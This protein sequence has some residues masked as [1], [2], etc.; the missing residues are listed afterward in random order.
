MTTAKLATAVLTGATDIG[1]AIA[2][3]DL[4]LV[5]DGAGGTLRKTAAS[6]LK[7]YITGDLVK[8]GSATIGTSAS[9][10]LNG[11]FTSDYEN[12][13]F[14]LNNIH[15][16]TA[17]AELRMRYIFGG[18]VASGSNYSH[19]NNAVVGGSGIDAADENYKGYG[20]S[21]IMLSQGQNTNQDY[22]GSVVLN[23]FQPLKNERH[24]FCQWN[25]VTVKTANGNPMTVTNGGGF[26]YSDLGA[27][28][29]L[30]FYGSNQNIALDWILYGVKN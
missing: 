17:T 29:G 26:Q 10:T 1:A 21:Y 7:T 30:Y 5:D 27:M 28:S 6:R 25:A 23:L 4:F 8:L 3:A 15:C 2:D 24:K 14:V 9:L 18:S 16:F 22:G 19:V 20:Q 13:V 12:Y 11:Y